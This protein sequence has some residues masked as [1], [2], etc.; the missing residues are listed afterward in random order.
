MRLA[1]ESVGSVKLTALPVWV[2][3]G[4]VQS[5]AGLRRTKGRSKVEFTLFASCLLVSLFLS[6]EWDLNQLSF[7]F[8]VLWSLSSVWELR[9]PVPQFSGLQTADH[10]TPQPPCLHALSPHNKPLPISYR[11]VQGDSW[12]W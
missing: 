2:W 11:L 6:L 10:R 4:I 5:I 7:W 1:F 9:Q 12:K 8:L 3:V